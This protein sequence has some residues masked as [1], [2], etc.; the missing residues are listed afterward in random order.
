M[1]MRKAAELH[2]Q[3]GKKKPMKLL[4]IVAVIGLSA[5]CASSPNRRTVEISAA[6]LGAD[7]NAA[8]AHSGRNLLVIRN[9]TLIDGMGRPPVPRT[10][11]IR[12]GKISRVGS[13][14]AVPQ[15][16]QII[17][18]DGLT[19]IPGLIDAHVHSRPWM[20]HL[21]LQFG[22]TTVR[23]VGSDPDFIFGVSG[24]GIPRIYACGPLLDG[25]PP[26]WGTRW[27]GSVGLR[28][29]QEARM[30]AGQLIKRALHA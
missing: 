5:A 13:E 29:V 18:A 30:A 21:F 1:V 26:V 4:L 3:T 9:A 16:S 19:V 23:D 12:S 25:I 28:S 8:E 11:I 22:V 2:C 20:W 24:G 14:S 17:D 6:D 15:G 27:A 7:R 10:T